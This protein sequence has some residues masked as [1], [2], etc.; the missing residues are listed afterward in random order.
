MEKF[1]NIQKIYEQEVTLDNMTI[2]TDDKEVDDKNETETEVE[3]E[4]TKPSDSTEVVKVEAEISNQE[5][6][7]VSTTVVNPTDN[8]VETPT[9][10]V[11]PVGDVKSFFSKLFEARGVAHIYHLTV[12]SEEGSF[13]AHV[14]LGDYYENLL[15]MVDDLIETYMGQYDLITEYKPIDTNVT[16]SKDRV[17]YFGELAVYIKEARKCINTEDTHLHNIID[18]IVAITYKLLYKLRF[19]K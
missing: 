11:K 17:A 5:A 12:N 15:P 19:N 3:V 4:V 18:E 6:E 2:K 16:K 9:E 8:T 1:T 13:A 10:E 14:A 7:V